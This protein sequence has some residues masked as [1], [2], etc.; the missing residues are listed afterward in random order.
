MARTS[1]KPINFNDCHSQWLFVN[2]NEEP[3][4]VF[5]HKSSS[6]PTYFQ[7]RISHIANQMS[8]AQFL[9]Y[10]AKEASLNL[11]FLK[12]SVMFGLKNLKL[13]FTSE[14]KIL[15]N[16]LK[17]SKMDINGDSNGLSMF[18]VFFVF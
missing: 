17:Y 18:F 9:R 16:M 7:S 6:T 15:K 2:Y 1:V 11:K 12:F 4:E 14:N 8:D 10:I 3:L 5:T 13:S